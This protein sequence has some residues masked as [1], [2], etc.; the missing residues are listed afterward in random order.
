ME[1]VQDAEA[2][3]EEAGYEFFLTRI[4][5]QDIFQPF[6]Y[7]PAVVGKLAEDFCN[8]ILWFRSR[9]RELVKKYFALTQS[10][11]DNFLEKDEFGNAE[12]S[13]K[14]LSFHMRIRNQ[15]QERGEF[16]PLNLGIRDFDVPF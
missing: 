13:L 1:V 12:T 9:Q 11:T 8:S 7:Y 14:M 6:S 15:A 3:L 2:I 4:I 16:V 5:V 10:E